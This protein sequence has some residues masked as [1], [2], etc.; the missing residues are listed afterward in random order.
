MIRT[1]LVV[2]VGLL[3]ANCAGAQ[4]TTTAQAGSSGNGQASAEASGQG[5][6]ASANGSSTVDTT[7]KAP[8]SNAMLAD[9]T[10]FNATLDKPIDTKKCKAGDSVT[11]RTTEGV[12]SGEKTMIPKGTKIVGHVTQASARANGQ[13]DSTLGIVF[14]K[15]VMKNG[16]EVPMSMAIQAIG[17]ASGSAST[18]T[19]NLELNGG[20]GG[21]AGASAG[22]AGRGA[23]GGV[24][25]TSAGLAGGVTN[26]AA[27]AGN[28][29][30]GTVDAVSRTT[31]GVSTG[32][33][34]AG[35][36]LNSAGQFTSNSRGVFG[37]NG[38]NLNATGAG[39]TQGSLITSTGKNVH[40]DS[41][42][43][44]LLVTQASTAAAR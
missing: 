11:A 21:Y 32:A 12:K 28:I 10:A 38:V 31:S 18:S 20:G 41:G 25:S 4:G 8:H 3:Y 44:M 42:T 23:L 33:N 27:G 29:A 34:G 30:G 43:R 26:T 35:G 22:G 37:L 13:A 7:A 6:Q 36:A 39:S 14:D 40:L 15:A 17:A 1:G 5:A 19:D 2:L 24:S 16:Q 9:G